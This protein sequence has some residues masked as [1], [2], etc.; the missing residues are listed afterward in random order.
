[1]ARAPLPR[2]RWPSA[3]VIP[4]CSNAS[5]ADSDRADARFTV[6]FTD[7]PAIEPRRN[8]RLVPLFAP[9]W[10]A[11]ACAAEHIDAIVRRLRRDVRREDL[12]ASRGA[13]VGGL[14]SSADEPRWSA[15]VV[16]SERR[17][18]GLLGLATLAFR[19]RFFANRHF[20]DNAHIISHK[21]LHVRPN[22]H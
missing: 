10:Q 11:I 18:G 12:V 1:M 6:R 3:A 13:S 5:S 22:M 2:P 20:H 15:A 9:T 14:N 7:A 4:L 21:T 19:R 17:R 16:E 8:A